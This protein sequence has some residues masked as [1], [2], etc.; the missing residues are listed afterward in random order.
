MSQDQVIDVS[1]IIDERKV[2]GLSISL[3][4]WG[5]FITLADGY[6][7]WAAAV[8]APSWI[9]AWHIER[10]T[11]GPVLSASVFGILFG[12]PFLGYIGDRLGRK[13]AIVASCLVFGLFSGLAALA[14]NLD[15][16]IVLRFL[17]GV[18]IGGVLPNV[19]TLN[20]EFA[21]KRF[22][23]TLVIIM[24]CGIT[25]GGALPG[26]VGAWLVP[27]YGWQLLFLLGGAV[28]VLVAIAVAVAM[29]ESI[30][31]LA[32]RERHRGAVMALLRRMRPEL[33]VAPEARFVLR[34][35]KPY[36]RFSAKDLFADG[37]GLITPLLWIC[38]AANLM[39]LYFLTSWMPTLLSGA[40]ISPAEASLAT[41]LFQLGGT[42]G[43]FA[44]CRPL[45]TTGL[46]PVAILFALA[47]PVVGAIGFA[48]GISDVLLLSVVFLGGVCVLGLQFGLNAASA[49]IY[50]TAFRSNGSGWA[51]GVGRIGSITGPLAGGVLVGLQ[52]SLPSLYLWSTIPF[53][54]GAVASIVLVR[55]Y[56]ARFGGDELGAQEPVART[57]RAVS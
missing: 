39:G 56:A 50:P 18:G 44:L 51:F 41:S 2:D 27:Q 14:S 5:F 47:V 22:R 52:L 9:R 26:V 16:L 11:L 21:P 28:P 8:A 20:A 46:A 40:N 38:F 55:L 13:T 25:V 4:V 37:L 6:D 15:E 30:R 57:P 35:E 54:L 1:A 49:M 32:M 53:I 12:A 31:Y 3:V 33:V 48:A 23:A 17:A 45:D 19:I 43:A 10:A 7:L 42:V 29:P 24:F 36:A 34:D